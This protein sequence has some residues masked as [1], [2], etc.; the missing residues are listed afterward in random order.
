MISFSCPS[1]DSPTS[2]DVGPASVYF[3]QSVLDVSQAM[4]NMFLISTVNGREDFPAAEDVFLGYS[5]EGGAA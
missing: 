2:E 1:R 3:R 4:R 5:L